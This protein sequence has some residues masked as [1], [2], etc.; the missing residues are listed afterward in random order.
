MLKNIIEYKGRQITA[1]LSDDLAIRS[2]QLT[3]SV[4]TGTE[5][6]L[7]SVC[8]AMLEVEFIGTNGE[9]EISAGDVLTL[10]KQPEEGEAVQVG[11]FIAE[12]PETTGGNS[13]KVTAYDFVT[14]LDKD[15]TQ[16][17]A[18][19]DAWPYT[20]LDFARMVCEECGLNLVT[21]EIPNG[22]Y[23]VEKF[24]GQG[25]TGRKLM[26]WVGELCGRFIRATAE[27]KIELTWYKENSVKVGPEAGTGM[28]G[29]FS[30][31]LSYSD[32]SVELI[33]A[34]QIQSSQD[35]VGVIYPA[36]VDAGNAYRITGNYL[37]N[38]DDSGKLYTIAETLYTQLSNVVYRPCEI[39]IPACLDVEVGDI[40]NITDKNG[41]SFDTYLM[42]RTQKGQRDT[43]SGTGSR[44]RNS[45]TAKNEE[46][47][48]SLNTKM[49]EMRKSIEGLD[50]KAFALQEGIDENTAYINEQTAAMRLTA[51]GISADVSA[52]KDEVSHMQTKV[53]TIKQSADELSVAVQSILDNGVTKIKTGL[54]LTISDTAITIDKEGSQLVNKL[55]DSGMSVVRED[56]TVILQ[57]NATGVVATDVRARNYLEIGNYARFEDHSDGTDGRRTACFWRGGEV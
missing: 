51:E 46:S 7:G 35:D 43:F 34:V 36:D 16:W 56:E 13:Y 26:S 41:F 12:M 11:S 33:D 57:A 25:V 6:T 32:Y 53:T 50:L 49:F 8:A 44:N 10:Y 38:T 40:V 24:A 1:G 37:I 19:L 31:G 47:F 22:D 42:S 2:V 52:Y 3:Q 29:I 18:G 5:L 27:G 39:S 23:P 15:L 20:L 28:L 9:L 4:N 14:R 30:G 45:T 54:G 48:R 55:D 17:L 21:E